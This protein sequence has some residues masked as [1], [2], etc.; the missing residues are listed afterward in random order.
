GTPEGAAPC[1]GSP[2]TRAGAPTAERTRSS[3]GACSTAGACARGSRPEASR[4]CGTAQGIEA[5]AHAVGVYRDEQPS[6]SR[7]VRL[8]EEC[9]VDRRER[10]LRRLAVRLHETD[11]F[12][13]LVELV[14]HL[15]RIVD[16]AD[17]RLD[18]DQVSTLLRRQFDARR[19]LLHLEL[20]LVGRPALEPGA[21]ELET[22]VQLS[23][24]RVRETRALFFLGLGVGLDARIMPQ[25][26]DRREA[27]ADT[28]LGR[29]RQDLRE[30]PGL[31]E[32]GLRI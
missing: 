29:R 22:P 14:L 2:S 26:R 8:A 16:R 11:L 12:R 18:R 27:H 25:G 4:S 23:L 20:R 6:R 17:E 5:P 28:R 19:G 7:A 1:A 32:I 9:E 15:A 30:T 10:I 21:R 31:R 3:A 24:L 13:D